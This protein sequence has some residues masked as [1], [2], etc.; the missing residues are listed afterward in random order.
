MGWGN[1]Q[2]PVFSQDWSL[3]VHG[4]AR[5]GL[6]LVMSPHVA[7]PQPWGW[8]H[9]PVTARSHHQTRVQGGMEFPGLMGPA[10]RCTVRTSG[11]GLSADPDLDQGPCQSSP[12]LD[13]ARSPC[14]WDP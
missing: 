8:T 7:F 12:S 14:S 3:G 2:K 6:V 9:T 1:H 4:Q 11:A 10:G 13:P 5:R